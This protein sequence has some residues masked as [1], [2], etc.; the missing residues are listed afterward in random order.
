MKNTVI[1]L[2]LSTIGFMNIASAADVTAADARKSYL[3]MNSQINTVISGSLC[4]PTKIANLREGKQLAKELMDEGNYAD[5]QL[6]AQTAHSRANNCN[7]A[8]WDEAMQYNVARGSIL[9]AG[10]GFRGPVGTINGQ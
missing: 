10:T 1:A 5:A 8:S 7:S 2:A 3:A 4:N 9:S 6:V